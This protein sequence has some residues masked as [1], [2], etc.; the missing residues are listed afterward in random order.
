MFPA[1]F[2]SASGKLRAQTITFAP[3]VK[4]PSAMTRPIPLDPPVT[5]ATLF[6]ML[7][8]IRPQGI[9]LVTFT[10]CAR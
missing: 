4:K 6:S 7:F 5:I 9:E 10:Y 2:I 8:T 1:E 3:A